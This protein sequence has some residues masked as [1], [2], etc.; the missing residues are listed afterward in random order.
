M[1]GFKAKCG[2]F[3]G[4]KTRELQNSELQGL[5]VSVI[6][7]CYAYEQH[8]HLQRMILA[9]AGKLSKFEHVKGDNVVARQYAN[10][11]GNNTLASQSGSM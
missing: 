7:R 2:G 3:Q 6:S 8:G 9:N 5:L 10:K 1:K 4:F 11:Q